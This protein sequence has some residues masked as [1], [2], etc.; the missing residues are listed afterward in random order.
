MIYYIILYIMIYIIY[1]AIYIYHNI[2]IYIIIY[3]YIYHNIISHVNLLHIHHGISLIYIYIYSLMGYRG[4]ISYNNCG[5]RW[6][7]TDIFHD[8]NS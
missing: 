8:G 4:Y 7:R 5:K 6:Y 2:Y 1:N 3:I